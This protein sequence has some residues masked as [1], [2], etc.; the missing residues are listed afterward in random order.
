LDLGDDAFI[1]L[2]LRAYR[3]RPE[4]NRHY[5]L[6]RA[7]PEVFYRNRPLTAR[8]LAAGLCP[9]YGRDKSCLSLGTRSGRKKFEY[10]PQRPTIRYER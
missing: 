1:K 4:I 2:D 7:L 9:G 10:C 6:R 5:A 8:S 3:Q